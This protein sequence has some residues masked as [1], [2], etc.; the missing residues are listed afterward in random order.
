MTLVPRSRVTCDLDRRESL[1]AMEFRQ[2]QRPHRSDH[3]D[4]GPFK[5]KSERRETSE[6]RKRKFMKVNSTKIRF[7]QTMHSSTNVSQFDA[8]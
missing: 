3:S 8:H 5:M 6:K 1:S 7:W 4:V 2:R